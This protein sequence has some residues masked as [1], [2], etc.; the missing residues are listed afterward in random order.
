MNLNQYSEAAA[1][2]GISV[3][4][5]QKLRTAVPP[6]NEQEQIAL[7]IEKET[8]LIDKTISRTELEIEF[9]PVCAT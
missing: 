5:I 1:Q 4:K 9:V 2:P 8:A 3:E 7:F 6:L